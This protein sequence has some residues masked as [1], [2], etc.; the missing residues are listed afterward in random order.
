[1]FSPK[2][3]LI[4]LL[5]AISKIAERI[6]LRPLEESTEELG[7]FSSGSKFAKLNFNRNMHTAFLFVHVAK[8]YDRVWYNGLFHKMKQLQ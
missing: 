6:I 1:M 7:D 8:A 3:R 5:S 4:N 2:Y